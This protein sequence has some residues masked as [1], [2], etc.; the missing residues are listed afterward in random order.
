MAANGQL[1]EQD[2]MK[3][4]HFHRVLYNLFATVSDKIA[5]AERNP[6][7][8]RYVIFCQDYKDGCVSL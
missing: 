4:I 6:L 8:L 7:K 2:D 5:A 3:V 1:S